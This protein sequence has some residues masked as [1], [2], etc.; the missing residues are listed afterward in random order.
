MDSIGF[1]EF[2]QL[3]VPYLKGGMGQ[4]EY[5][6]TLLL[7][8]CAFEDLEDNPVSKASDDSMKRYFT[9]ERGIGPLASKIVPY[10]DPEQLEPFFKRLGFEAE[11]KLYKVL[12]PYSS[13]M[14]DLNVVEEA[15]K[16]LAE[17]IT[18]ASSNKRGTRKRSNPQAQQE[19]ALVYIQEADGR[20]VLCGRKLIKVAFGKTIFMCNV[21]RITPNS[22]DSVEKNNLAK[23]GIELPEQGS[24]DDF[25]AL[26]P[27]CSKEYQASFDKDS[28]KRLLEIKR[29]LQM[30]SA[31]A[32]QLEQ[33]DLNEKIEMVLEGLCSLSSE[34]IETNLRLD[35][36]ALKD[37]IEDSEPLL[38]NRIGADVARYY[39]F[40]ES[41][42]RRLSEIHGSSFNR[43][44]AKQVQLA[45][46]TLSSSGD[47]QSVIYEALVD[48][49]HE[50]E[51]ACER[52]A[53]EIVVSFFVQNCEVFDEI[54]R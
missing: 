54:A 24:A 32:D 20:C 10:L 42:L 8:I 14:T 27:N 49:I 41:G 51:P 17:I 15:P 45:Y 37:K 25:I 35:A 21:T 12:S 5:A 29:S 2:A 30:R 7:G 23:E 36:L 43:T 40:I 48:W 47:S 31:A 3:T 28:V 46:L 44:I 11:M 39:R 6:R 19:E 16:I 13:S 38:K 4:A 26:C 9:G 34:E 18:A 53:C 33:C 52:I 1:S 50:K 22:L